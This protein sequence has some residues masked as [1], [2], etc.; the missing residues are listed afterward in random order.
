METKVLNAR[1][2]IERRAEPPT[3]RQQVTQA[4]DPATFELIGTVP[5][6]TEG[7]IPGMVARARRAAGVWGSAPFPERSRVLTRLRDLALY[8]LRP[9][10]STAPGLARVEVQGGRV[11]VH[12]QNGRKVPLVSEVVSLLSGLGIQ[13]RD[14]QTEQSNLEDVFLSL[15]GRELRE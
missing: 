8:Q 10:L 5:I 11:V 6:T 3:Y 9:V 14:L 7:Q 15:T 13:F 4:L 12:G 2:R 1:T